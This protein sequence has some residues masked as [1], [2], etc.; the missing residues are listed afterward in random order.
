[1][2]SFDKI[3]FVP[4]KDL[5]SLSDK[6]ESFRSELFDKLDKCEDGLNEKINDANAKLLEVK[7]A[8]DDRLTENEDRI[9]G[10]LQD[11]EDRLQN[12]IQVRG[13]AEML[14][15]QKA[16]G[17]FFFVRSEKTSWTRWLRI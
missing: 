8:M 4:S 15:D 6:V 12:E 7:D 13:M 9:K 3:L 10:A 16:N 11:L 17:S 14:T 1:M 5:Q 2:P